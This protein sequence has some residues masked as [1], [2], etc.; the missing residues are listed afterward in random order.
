MSRAIYTLYRGDE[1][2]GTGTISEL[3]E[4][5][6]VKKDTMQWYATPSARKRGNIVA[7]YSGRV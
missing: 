2:I 4:L 3:A 1:V 6:E 7:I 5:W